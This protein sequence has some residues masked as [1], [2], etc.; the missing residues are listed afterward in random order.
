MFA[1]K[2]I[3][4]TGKHPGTQSRPACSSFTHHAFKVR[5]SSFKVPSRDREGG[6]ATSLA[7]VEIYNYNRNFITVTNYP[8]TGR[9]LRVFHTKVHKV[10]RDQTTEPEHL[11][12]SVIDCRNPLSQTSL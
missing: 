7:L 12:F 11:S 9:K 3:Y 5:L 2:S 10:N 1:L 8:M 6:A 4:F